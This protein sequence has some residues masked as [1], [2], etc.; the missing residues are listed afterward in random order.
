MMSNR[1]LSSGKMDTVKKVQNLAVVLTAN[2]EV[3]THE[4]AQVVVHDLNLFTTVQVLEETPAVL[5]RGKL[6]VDQRYSCEWVSDQEPR[7]TEDG[8]SIICEKDNFVP[9][10][11]PGLFTIPK[12]SSSSASLSQDSLRREA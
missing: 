3:Q 6:C 11:V 8:K 4:E 2:E 1:E 9:L 7:L 5:S 10:V 12:S